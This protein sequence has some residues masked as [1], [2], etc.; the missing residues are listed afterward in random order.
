[1]IGAAD[2]RAGEQAPARAAVLRTVV[3]C[4]LVDSTALNEKLGD[5]RATDLFR[6]H[7]RMGRDLLQA[8]HG[9][10]IDKTD[11]FLALFERPTQGAAFAIE[12]QL[13][14]AELSREAGL[15]L[16]ARIGIHLGDVLLWENAADDVA[17][18]A[19][20]VEL[21]GLVK[22]IAARLMGL[23][24]PGQILMSGLSH[25]L[26]TR[27]LEEFGA[28]ASALRF[29][30]YGRYRLKGVN[31]AIPVYE[32]GIEGHSPFRRPRDGDKAHRDRPWWLAPRALTLAAVL[33]AIGAGVAFW[34]ASLG[35]PSFAFAPRDWVVVADLQNR[36]GESTFDDSLATAFRI[37]LEQSRHV[38]VLSDLRIR[39]T[40]SRM[41][42]DA[43]AALDPVTAAEVAER[44]GARAVIVPS[45]S[46]VGG[47]LTF[48]A[49][50]VDPATRATVFSDSAAGKGAGSALASVDRV[51]RDLRERLG[52]AISSIQGQSPPLAK[53][54]TESL[55]ALRAY[56]LAQ[57]EFASGRLPDAIALYEQAIRFD[58]G[59]ALAHMGLA[60]I[61]ISVDERAR[62][63]AELDKA[64]ALRERLPPRDAVYLDAWST[65]FGKPAER[66]AQW[67]LLATLY[68]D[69]FAGY[70]NYAL[71][72]WNHYNDFADALEMERKANSPHNPFR[73]AVLLQMAI[74]E[75]G[76]ERHDDALRDVRLSEQ[77]GET[78]TG[79]VAAMILL[80][81]REVDEARAAVAEDEG[82]GNLIGQQP[83]RRRMARATIAAD[84]G[85][86]QE[87]ARE[88]EALT[89]GDGDDRLPGFGHAA[90]LGPAQYLES[91]ALYRQR[92]ARLAD[93]E[94]ARLASGPDLDR[95]HTVHTLMLVAYLSARNGSEPLARRILNAAADAAEHDGYPANRAMLAIA[96]AEL[97][98]VAGDPRGAIDG[99]APLFDGRELFLAHVAMLDACASADRLEDALREADWLI[100]HRGRALAEAASDE[101]GR[102]HNAIEHNLAGLRA[103]EL[104]HRLGRPALAR[105][106]LAA[107]LAAWPK[108]RDFPGLAGRIDALADPQGL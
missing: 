74:L 49:E 80:A 98:R 40:L 89:A 32:I 94:L 67:K 55:D 71:Y 50:V 69:Y 8:H 16:H 52:E 11:G 84:Q 54:T 99:L 44:E 2:A 42:R 88:L 34:L 95:D 19:K 103:A 60:R 93:A 53:V 15:P 101:V 30:S 12:Y 73:G 5:A 107:F 10:E 22:P 20:P 79:V 25:T 61:W 29:R 91:Q 75:L 92:L 62:S 90:A 97:R 7:D 43:Q 108:A 31:D 17:Q 6:R 104:A 63:K 26:V 24:L 64:L 77:D 14:L 72:A 66:L 65:N 38:N 78:G 36:T 35:Q 39:D 100:R 105:E 51:A 18:G 13:R 87:L 46:E 56:T 86:P 1:M 106:R 96:R 59:F 41:R 23:A 21:G 57:R 9:R 70:H 28:R 85:D 48:R 82:R 68:P 58:A 81:R 102:A 47:R 83:M 76:L 33:L 37:G 4:D 3:I 45:L 27:A